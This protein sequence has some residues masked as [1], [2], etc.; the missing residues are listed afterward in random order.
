MAKT[1]P[2]TVQYR[3]LYHIGE[4]IGLGFVQA[5]TEPE[6]RAKFQELHPT[7]EIEKV[8]PSAANSGMYF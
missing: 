3:V 6:A 5:E 8:V 7:A 1:K 2:K 4:L